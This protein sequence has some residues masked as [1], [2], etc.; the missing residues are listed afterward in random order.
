MSLSYFR[1]C[2]GSI[3]GY[4]SANLTAL[5]RMDSILLMP[6]YLGSWLLAPGSNVKARFLPMRWTE[7]YEY[8]VRVALRVALG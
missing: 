8:R 5:L 1:I 4:F 7:L 3:W 2:F 6:S